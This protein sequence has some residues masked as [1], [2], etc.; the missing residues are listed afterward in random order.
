VF[1]IYLPEIAEEMEMDS[2][3][4]GA[5]IEGRNFNVL[6]KGSTVTLTCKVM[7]SEVEGKAEKASRIDWIKNGEPVNIKVE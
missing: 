6:K 1:L 4:S 5:T 7:Q 3:Y 2:P